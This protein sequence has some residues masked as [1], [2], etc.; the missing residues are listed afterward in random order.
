MS[1]RKKITGYQLFKR[2]NRAA[3][4]LELLG[5]Y[6]T[7]KQVR[8]AIHI[9]RAQLDL[10]DVKWKEWLDLDNNNWVEVGHPY[11]AFVYSTLKKPQEQEQETLPTKEPVNDNVVVEEADN[12]VW[13]K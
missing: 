5:I 12:D 6:E 11:I 3:E 8:E 13:E 1:K 7:E 10:P 4:P 9:Y 2:D